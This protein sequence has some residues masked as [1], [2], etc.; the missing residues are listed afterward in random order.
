MPARQRAGGLAPVTRRRAMPWRRSP[1]GH[2][3]TARH[4]VTRP[5]RPGP[6]ARGADEANSAA[7]AL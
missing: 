2:D 5:V 4:V 3:G 7:A 1:V 6:S